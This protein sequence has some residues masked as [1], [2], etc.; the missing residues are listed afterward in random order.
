MDFVSDTL[1]T[2]RCFRCLTVLDEH[3]RGSLAVHVA[4][5]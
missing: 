4:H 1:I 3:T 5:S 2:G